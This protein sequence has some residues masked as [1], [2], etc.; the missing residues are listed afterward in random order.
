MMTVRERFPRLFAA[1]LLW[2]ACAGYVFFGGMPAF[3]VQMAADWHYTATQQGVIAMAEVV[4]NAIGSLLLVYVIHGRTAR[5]TL[6]C[7]LLMQLAGNAAMYG[8]PAFWLAC[9]ERVF[10]GIGGGIVFGT[11]IRYVSLNPRADTL[12]PLMVVAEEDAAVVGAV[13]DVPMLDARLAIASN[14]SISAVIIVSSRF[15]YCCC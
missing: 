10:A 14:C 2:L 8:D 5:F 4:G 11:A 12:L 15:Q 7:G 6:A 1:A 9:C 3:V 13:D